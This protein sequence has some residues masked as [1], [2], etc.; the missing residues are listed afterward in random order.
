MAFPAKLASDQGR[1]GAVAMVVTAIHILTSLASLSSSAKAR[2]PNMSPTTAIFVHCP[3]P[4]QIISTVPS[5]APLTRT[6]S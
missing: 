2:H 5:A 1:A 3:P 6:H 4:H